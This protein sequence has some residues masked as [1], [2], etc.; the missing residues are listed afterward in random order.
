MNNFFG[1]QALIFVFGLIAGSFLNCL[2]YRLPKGIKVS[3]GRS[4]C[5]FCGENL[6]AIHLIPILSYLAQRGKCS[7]CKSKIPLRYL[8]VELALPLL[9]VYGF[10]TWGLS[11][12]FLYFALISFFIVGLFFTDLEKYVLPDKLML[13]AIFVA[14]LWHVIQE[15]SFHSLF[16]GVIVGAGFFAI[17]YWISKGKWVGEG[18]IW[19]GALMGIMFGFPQVLISIWIAY[20]MGGIVGFTLLI[21]K[22]KNLNSKIP[23]GTFLAVSSLIMFFYGRYLPIIWQ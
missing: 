20:V 9:W 18:D 12:Y 13:P 21:S 5:T 6:K 17:Q 14:F 19:F 2:I 4:R 22:K 3:K 7:F 11:A 23:F 1:I 8:I 16:W 10:L 15:R